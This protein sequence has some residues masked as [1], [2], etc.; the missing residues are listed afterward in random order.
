MDSDE[1]GMGSECGG[2]GL[3]SKCDGGMGSEVGSEG[4]GSGVGVEEGFL[5]G[6][7]RCRRAGLGRVFPRC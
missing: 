5:E 4:G 3:G 7:L 2:S 6:G 1:G